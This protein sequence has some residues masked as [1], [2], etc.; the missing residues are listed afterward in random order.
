MHVLIPELIVLRWT[1]LRVH[2]DLLV[3]F[4]VLALAPTFNVHHFAMH[5]AFDVE[6]SRWACKESMNKVF[7]SILRSKLRRKL[8]VSY[9]E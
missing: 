2:D 5:F 7:K 8:V 9:S 1:L 3:R 4:G 6:K